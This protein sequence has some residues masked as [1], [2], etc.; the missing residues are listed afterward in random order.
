M[1]PRSSSTSNSSQ[2]DNPYTLYNLF[3]R[4]N[5]AENNTFGNYCVNLNEMFPNEE[6]T[7]DYFKNHVSLFND[8]PVSKD[9]IIGVPNSLTYPKFLDNYDEKTLFYIFYFMTKDSLQF[10]AGLYLYRKGW[11]YNYKNQIWFQKIGDSDKWIFFNPLEWKK[12]DYIFGPVDD[13]HFL[14]EDDAKSY[15]KLYEQE[16]KKENKRRQGHK[17]NANNSH[18]SNNQHVNNNGSNSQKSEQKKDNNA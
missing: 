3:S 14:D 8:D 1:D 11:L 16:R 9:K 7:K 2:K 17:G 15:L 10:Y 12:N 13:Q 6:E 5:K 4:L 18:S